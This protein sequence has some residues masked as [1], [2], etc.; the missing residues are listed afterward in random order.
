MW[1][2]TEQPVVIQSTPS[3]ALSGT[4]TV[5]TNISPVYENATVD[6]S[7][8]IA[9]MSVVS[10]DVYRLIVRIVDE[11]STP[12]LNEVIV[13]SPNTN[14]VTNTFTASF[15]AAFSPSHSY[16]VMIV[17]QRGSAIDTIVQGALVVL[18]PLSTAADF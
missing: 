1:I 6:L 5:I 11:E 18:P 2:E 10:G 7:V 13:P 16:T 4:N 9:T 17:R 15:I 3:V 12:L 14:G 8:S